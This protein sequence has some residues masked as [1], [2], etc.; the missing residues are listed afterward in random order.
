M[1]S[2]INVS[3]DNGAALVS[4]R[5]DNDIPVGQRVR[6]RSRLDGP[7]LPPRRVGTPEPGWD[8]EGFEGVVP[9]GSTVALNYTVPL[10]LPGDRDTEAVDADGPSEHAIDVKTL[11]HADGLDET[12]DSTSEDVIRSL[13]L[14]RPPADAVPASADPPPTVSASEAPKSAFNTASDEHPDPFL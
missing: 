12:T 8:D 5:I 10:S 13:G 7:V 3:V 6:L 11:G 2:D 9:M 1:H 4:A 14:A